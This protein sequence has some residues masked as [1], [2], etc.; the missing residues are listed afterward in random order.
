MLTNGRFPRWAEIAQYHGGSTAEGIRWQF[1]EM[2]K[3]AELMRASEDGQTADAVLGGNGAVAGGVDKMENSDNNKKGVK[4]R[5]PAAAKG[6]K[7]KKARVAKAA[8]TEQAKVEGLDD[9]EG[10]C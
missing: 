9:E 4:R 2:K 10:E 6:P 3:V 7:T 5:A 1:S 8:K